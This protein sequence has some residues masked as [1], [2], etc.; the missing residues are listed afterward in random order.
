MHRPAT[1]AAGLGR[2]KHGAGDEIRSHH[3][4]IY[5]QSVTRTGLILHHF[6]H[7]KGRDLSSIFRSF[8]NSF[9]THKFELHQLALRDK[10]PYVSIRPMPR[11]KRNSQK[12][13]VRNTLQPGENLHGSADIHWA[14]LVGPSIVAVI[15]L[16]ISLFFVGVFGGL[17]TTLGMASAG[18]C[19]LSMIPLLQAAIYF[20]TTE[21]AITSSR[22]L[23][24]TGLISRFS[25]EIAIAK[26]ESIL[27]SQGIIGRIFDFGTVT[28]LGTGGNKVV[29]RGI[30]FPMK[31]R[32]T[33]QSVTMGS[34][35]A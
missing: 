1:P 27:L 21:T 4:F 12:S 9:R 32:A 11:K 3:P 17:K 18:I 19:L 25:D 7:R 13:Y 31:F 8:S 2:K 20:Q 22:V 14:T 34:S 33:V 5:F 15:W 10:H 24:K 35:V 23:L 30:A 26:V 16:L 6:V 28:V 29:L